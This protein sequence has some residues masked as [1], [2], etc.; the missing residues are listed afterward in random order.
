MAIHFNY[1]SDIHTKERTLKEERKV[2]NQADA[3]RKQKEEAI[4]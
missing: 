4:R 2:A 1:A 3:V